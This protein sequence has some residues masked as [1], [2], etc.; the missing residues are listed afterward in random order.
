MISIIVTLIK[1]MLIL[2]M[3]IYTSQCFSVFSKKK[4]KTR[5]RVLR[6]QIALILLLVT[7]AFTAMFL[8]TMEQKM[9]ILYGVIVAYIIV[10]QSPVPP[11]LPQ[12]IDPAF[13]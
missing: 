11:D 5:R 1:Y 9:L 12:G 2:L 3:I 8:Q 13:K 6:R 10:V 4:E 7:M